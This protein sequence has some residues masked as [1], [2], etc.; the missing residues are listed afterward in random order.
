MNPQYFTNSK[1]P[2]LGITYDATI[3]S[4][5][6]VSIISGASSLFVSAIDKGIFLN[7][8]TTAS[9]S[10]FKEFIPANTTNWY[11]IPDGTSTVEFIEETTTAKLVVIQK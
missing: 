7:W 6:S 1:A 4:S 2:T 11:V 3:S 9:S 8:G 10:A 5:T